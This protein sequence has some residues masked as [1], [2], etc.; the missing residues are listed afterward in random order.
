MD[1][2]ININTGGKRYGVDFTNNYNN[3]YRY[4]NF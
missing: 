4:N 1:F 2:G 3:N